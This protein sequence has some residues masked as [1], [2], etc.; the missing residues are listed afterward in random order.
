MAR[1]NKKGTLDVRVVLRAPG[2]GFDELV[3]EAHVR[4][5]SSA[6]ALAGSNILLRVLRLPVELDERAALEAARWQVAD[7]AAGRAARYA[8]SGRSPDGSWCVVAAAAP[9]DEVTSLSAGVVDL[10]VL[11]LWRG[12]VHLLGGESHLVVVEVTSDGGRVVAGR[13]LPEFAREVAA[14]SDA[15]LQR[16]LMYV[17]SELG[18]LRLARVGEE[19]PEETVAVGL[20]LHR[21]SGPSVN[22]RG[23]ASLKGLGKRWSSL[24]GRD[25]I[26]VTAIALVLAAL[27]HALA[28][29]YS[30]QAGELEK[31][32]ASLKPQAEA[33][34]RTTAEREKYEDWV[35]IVKSFSTRPAWP[36][37]ED[38][39]RAVPEKVWLT[40]Y[41]AEIVQQQPVV[42][43]GG[44]NQGTIPSPGQQQAKPVP[45]QAAQLPPVPGLLK[46][47]GYSLDLASVGLFRDNLEK[48]PWCGGVSVKQVEW[49]DKLGA[50][51]FSM[52]VTVNYP[53][54]N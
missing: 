30:L 53:L 19:L 23:K 12:A 48:L 20:A 25:L 36:Q 3:S 17:R 22:F 15:D 33:C 42:R 43:Q 27:P 8:L 31:K 16:T 35:A 5:A 47:E 4:P 13:G 34:A 54:M 9:A 18:D 14:G 49:D 39:R 50:H 37:V 11:A 24:A 52:E 26:R 45:K 29:G 46:L 1:R 32:A 40:L 28:A 44:G 21:F 2:K 7:A 38:V 10:R 41:S 51:K 6:V